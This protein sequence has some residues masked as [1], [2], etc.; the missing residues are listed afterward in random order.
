MKTALYAGS[1]DP[2]TIG[3]KSIVDRALN[4]FDRIVI[5][6]GVNP[7]KKQWMPIEERVSKI[8]ALYANEPRV[9]VISYNDL[10]VEVARQV[11]AQFLLRGVRSVVDFEFERQLADINRNLS[12][13][14]SVLLY[15]LPEH[16]SI[17]SSA[18]R[19]MANYGVDISPY[20]P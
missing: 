13:I 1:F 6:I 17:S 5:G 2:F 14:E 15:A 19:E 12:G 3:H 18:V 16:A 7:N 4:M 8:K 9:E 11:G 10:T 20:L